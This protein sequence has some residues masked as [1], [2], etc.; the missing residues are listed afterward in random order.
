MVH[1]VGEFGF[2]FVLIL[3]VS[4]G[5]LHEDHRGF[6][7]Q[8]LAQLSLHRLEVPLDH[9]ECRPLLRLVG[10]HGSHA[11]GASDARQGHGIGVGQGVQ[12]AIH[13]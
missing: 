5:V 2:K 11:A 3:I 1:K 7:R 10:R 9:T 12:Q 13:A 8:L 6:G 4:Q